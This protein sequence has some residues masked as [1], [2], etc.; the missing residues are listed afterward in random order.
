[1]LRRHDNDESPDSTKPYAEASW[2]VQSMGRVSFRCFRV[3]QHGPNA[4]GNDRLHVCCAGIELYG[5]LTQE[6]GMEVELQ[7]V[8]FNV[9]RF[10]LV[11]SSWQPNLIPYLHCMSRW[12]TCVG[13]WAAQNMTCSVMRSCVCWRRMAAAYPWRMCLG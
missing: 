7:V 11:T 12:T 13:L 1:M 5:V 3:L 10:H 8:A 2:S 4:K 9:G 6:E